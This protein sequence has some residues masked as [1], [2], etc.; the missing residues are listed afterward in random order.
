MKID[1]TIRTRQAGSNALHKYYAMMKGRGTY[2]WGN[3]PKEARA[4][5]NKRLL[6]ETTP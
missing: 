3:T 5:L 4:C 2:G 1:K 6:E